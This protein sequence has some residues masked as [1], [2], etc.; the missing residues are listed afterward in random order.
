M[1]ACS[2]CK[3]HAAL[4][5]RAATLRFAVFLGVVIVSQLGS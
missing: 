1:R 3:W 4:Q 5:S 2:L